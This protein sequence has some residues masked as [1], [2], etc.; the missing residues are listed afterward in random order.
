[1]LQI[2]RIV[3]GDDGKSVTIHSKDVRPVDQ[4]QLRLRLRGKDGELFQEEVLWTIHKVT[5]RR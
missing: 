1:V 4:L 2:D 3:V 5:A